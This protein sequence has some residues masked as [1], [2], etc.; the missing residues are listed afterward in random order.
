MSQ[1]LQQVY[2]DA[3]PF[4]AEFVGPNGLSV[5]P[6]GFGRSTFAVAPRIPL[7]VSGSGCRIVDDA[8]RE[9]IDVHNNFTALIHGHAHPAVVEAAER[10]FR[11]GSAF[12]LPNRVEFEH[13][14]MMVE[15]LDGIAQAAGLFQF[16][17]CIEEFT[18][19][20]QQ[21]R[22]RKAKADH[23]TITRA[24]AI[25]LAVRAVMARYHSKVYE[26]VDM[27]TESPLVHAPDPSADFQV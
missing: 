25:T 9:L 19:T 22:K 20:P 21:R 18:S 2:A 15:R 14:Q 24:D 12:G 6:G 3:E 8:G 5:L 1:S 10:A 26:T 11:N 4:S 17:G 7:A 23:M 13:A 16:C 27:A